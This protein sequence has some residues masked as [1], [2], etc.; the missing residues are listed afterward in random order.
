MEAT[1]AGSTLTLANLATVTESSSSYQATTAFEALS[2]GTVSLPA[3]HA[4]NTGT[5]H[6]E[7]D[8][9]NSVLNVAG[10]TGITEANGWT[11][12]TLQATNSGT[13]NDGG[14]VTLAGTNLTIDGTATIATAQL[15]SYA[16]GSIS[17]S[18]GSPSFAGL[19]S[20]NGSNVTAL[21]VPVGP[22]EPPFRRGPSPAY[23]GNVPA[24]T[25]PGWPHL[26]FWP[27]APLRLT[28]ANLANVTE[29]S[30][31]YAAPDR[32]RGP[33]R[34]RHGHA[35]RSLRRST[36]HGTVLPEADGNPNKR[37]NVPDSHQL[38]RGQRLDIIHAPGLQFRHGQRRR[39]GDPAECEPERRRAGRD[40]DA[41]HH[42]VLQRRQHHR[43]RRRL[44]Q[45]ARPDRLRR[46][47]HHDHHR[48]DRRR[49]HALPAQPGHNHRELQQLWV[50]GRVRGPLRRHGQ[51]AGAARDQHR[52]RLPGRRRRQQRAQ[53]RGPHRHHRGQRLDHL[54]PPG[55]ELRPGQRRAPAPGALWDEPGRSTAARPPSRRR[56]SSRS[57]AARSRSTG[58][59][60]ASPV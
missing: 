8:G 6:L 24:S 42:H 22:G 53:H 18:G 59:R 48:G 12:S 28:L 4:I 27:P 26:P 46:Q 35:C 19:T 41:R 55:D 34:R 30:N 10:L 57:R 29:G 5:V 14:L 36:K 2:G 56:R 31:S 1:G 50:H 3:L 13:V 25:M 7:A 52:H 17:I 32:V 15:T 16:G 20:F 23:A 9:A 43:Q 40:P 47:R 51:P 39:A 44:A 33:P 60:R 54:H 21:L 38:R 49:E 37:L 45:P 58:A 11:T